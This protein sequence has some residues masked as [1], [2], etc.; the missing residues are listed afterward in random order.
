[1]KLL[2]GAV[3][4]F[5]S[6]VAITAAQSKPDFPCYTVHAR[7]AVYTGDG[8]RDLWPIGSHR[9]LW[10]QDGDDKLVEKVLPNHHTHCWLGLT[11]VGRSHY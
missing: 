5:A 3:L 1:M 2:V 11:A 9:L 6:C 4:A 7:Y 8:V 10:V